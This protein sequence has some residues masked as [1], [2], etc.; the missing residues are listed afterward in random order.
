MAKKVIKYLMLIVAVVVLFGLSTCVFMSKKMPEGVQGPG[1]DELVDKMWKALNKEAWDSTK[2]VKWSFRDKHHYL[3]NRE[4]NLVQ[5]SWKKNR[6]LFNPNDVTGIVYV[7]EIK[8]SPQNSA[9]IIEKAWSYWCND[10]YWLIAPFKLK[11]KGVE[12]SIVK[13]EDGDRL[14][15]SYISG[16]VT[17]GDSY[18]WSFDQQ[19]MPESYEMYTSIIPVQG[20]EASWEGWISLSTGAKISTL[21]KMAKISLK[22]ENVSG[23]NILSDIGLE[24]DIWKELRNID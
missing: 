20:I 13:H 2:Y 22:I 3:W 16:G 8:Q 6:V 11:D 5:I 17:P 15:V 21:H 10:M 4:D 19:N 12:L 18:I 1:T 14:K 7:D 23:G 9:K 24:N